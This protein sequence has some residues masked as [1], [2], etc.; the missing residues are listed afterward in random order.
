M[1]GSD[2]MQ[3]TNMRFEPCNI[4]LKDFIKSEIQY[5]ENTVILILDGMEKSFD[6]LAEI[7]SIKKRSRLFRLVISNLCS[8]I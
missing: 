2:E 6:T 5:D 1:R 4:K 3:I 7:A 8:G